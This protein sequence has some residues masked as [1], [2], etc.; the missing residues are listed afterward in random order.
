MT[1]YGETLLGRSAHNLQM[2]TVVVQA[3]ISSETVPLRKGQEKKNN[4]CPAIEAY[5][6][7]IMFA[8]A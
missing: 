3:Q 5:C 1:N 6:L 7:G 4:K 2:C 8:E